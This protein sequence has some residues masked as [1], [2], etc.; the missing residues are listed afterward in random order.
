[1]EIKGKTALVTGAN[2]GL[3]RV[4][5]AAFLE[6][7]AS[8]VYAAARDMSSI[9][10]DRFVPVELD[11]TSPVQVA[12]A[13]STCTDVDILVNNAGIMLSTSAID[14]NSENALR[15]EMEVNVY[16]PLSLSK[17]FAPVLAANGGG[18]IVNMLSVV[19]W[20]VNPLNPTY[21]VSKH[22]AQAVTDALRIEL[23]AQGTGVI[24]VYAGFIDT[25]MGATLSSGPKTSPQQVA[26]RTIEGIQTGA[27]QVFADERAEAIWQA[28]RNDPAKLHADM[29]ALWKRSHGQSKEG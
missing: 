16:G 28:V 19:S 23:Q 8:K 1:M 15:R 17:A 9:G 4:F 13:A 29:Q 12:A 24:G 14:P 27:D 10:D 22:A 3:G 20:F 25:D 5:A 6:A 26:A 2:R 18:V 7:G 21:C 11:V